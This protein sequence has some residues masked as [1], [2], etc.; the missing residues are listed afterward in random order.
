MA[1]WTF[2]SSP[3]GHGVR[4][5]GADCGVHDPLSILRATWEHSHADSPRP[6]RQRKSPE[7]GAIETRRSSR[8]D[9][10]ARYGFRSAADV[11]LEGLDQLRVAVELEVCRA[12]P[13][14]NQVKFLLAHRE[15][16]LGPNDALVSMFSPAVVRGRR[17]ISSVFARHLRQDGV[18]AFQVSLLP[19]LDPPTIQKL[20]KAEGNLP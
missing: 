5:G 4:R 17:C 6:L 8:R 15:G 11:L 14:A 13:V 19:H 20:N 2:L 3:S 7:G 10:A 1:V 18:A 16:E 12:D 9:L